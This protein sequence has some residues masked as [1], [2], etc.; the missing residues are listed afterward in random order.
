MAIG[1]PFRPIPF[2]LLACGLLTA[3]AQ[4]ELVMHT[5]KQVQKLETVPAGDGKGVYKIGKPYQVKGRWYYPAEDHGYSKTGIASWYGDQFHGR[6][7]ANGE[8]FDMNEMTAAHKTLPLPSAVRVTNLENGRSIVLRVNDRGP[9][10]DGRII[11]VSRRGAQLLGFQNKGTARVRVSVLP[12]ESRQLKV[13]ALSSVANSEPQLAARS[14]PRIP[15][16]RRELPL[17]GVADTTPAAA[18]ETGEVR[19]AALEVR[20]LV[21]RTPV[22]PPVL[23]RNVEI[24]PVSPSGIYVQTGAFGELGNALR[25]RDLLYR[26]GI[27]PTQI[28]RVDFAEGSF[29]R[30]RVGPVGS[31]E[32]ADTLLAE[33]LGAG[34]EEAR[35]IVE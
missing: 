9:F 13:A 32:Q 29:F 8:V 24:L 10:V 4:T 3:C 34:V 5:A 26:G 30:V 21:Q 1:R 11:D 35:L 17:P 25:M 31:V 28:S 2:V 20:P 23:P 14:S 27:G 15:V 19:V 16:E 12:A 33:I 22:K 18:P 6:S 7:T